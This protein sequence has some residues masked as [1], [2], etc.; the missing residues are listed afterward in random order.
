MPA[1]RAQ[2]L[3]AN[4]TGDKQSWH[5]FDRYDFVMDDETM[6]I[7]SFKPPAEE[8]DA[9][10]SPVKGQRRCIVVVPAKAAQG[11]PWSWQA[12]YWNHE[13]QTEVEL[14]KRGFYVV[15][16]TPDPGKQWD[17]WYTFLTEKYN[18]AKKPAFIGMSKGGVNEYDWTTVHPDKVSCIYA[19]NPAI[20][21]EAFIK[22]GDLAKNDVP[23]LN[24]C[25][26]SDFLLE[27]HTLAIE[28]RYRELGGRIT[29]IIK[30]GP[31]HHPHSIRN[32]KI[33]ADWIESNMKL[34]KADPPDF[35]DKRFV[36]SYY[37][38]TSNSYTYLKEEDT[39]AISRGP[40][41]APCYERYD[42]I[43]NSQWG[44]TA[45]GIIVPNKTAP[46]KPWVFR[47]G[48]VKGDDLIDQALLSKGFHIVISPITAQAGS[49]RNQ[50]DS[51]YLFLTQH[52]FSKKPVMEGNGPYAGEV[53]AWA[54]LNPEKISA[55]YGENPLMRSLI[56]TTPLLDSLGVLA[57]KNVPIIHIS[58]SVD[59]WFKSQTLVLQKRYKALG[60]KITIIEKKGEGHFLHIN[61]PAPIVNFLSNAVQ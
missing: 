19:D 16:I 43:T 45:M 6:A 20:R 29:V 26:S 10:G 56:S 25:G 57:K 17:A 61:D 1:L 9:V 35:V 2:N 21:Q 18:L 47:C 31:A 49:M 15:F 60:G 46:G 13:P 40:G 39:Y 53:Y 32:P 44:I 37:Y 28:K 27:R 4:F 58:G 38:N 3:P 50:W 7:S 14:L 42:I 52:G 33:I 12:C 22:L 41:F 51:V 36:K 48:N 59:P 30:D 54:E 5:G 24:V 55:I 23:L 34:S 8:K 11:L